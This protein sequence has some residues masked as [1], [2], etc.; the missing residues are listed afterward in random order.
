MS[1]VP[2]RHFYIFL[3]R[4]N[5]RLLL[6]FSIIVKV[7]QYYR[8]IIGARARIV[9]IYIFRNNLLKKCFYNQFLLPFV[10]LV[11]IVLQSLLL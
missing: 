11:P 9:L 6:I 10:G 7:D 2:K 8:H 5:R 4:Q 3:D 1:S